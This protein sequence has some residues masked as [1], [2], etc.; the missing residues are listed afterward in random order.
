MRGINGINQP[1]GRFMA[2]LGCPH[3]WGFFYVPRSLNLTSSSVPAGPFAAKDRKKPG[4]KATVRALERFMS[5]SW[6]S[7]SDG[8][9]DKLW[10]PA[11]AKP[12]RHGW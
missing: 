8:V 4:M 9:P 1:N 3:Y 5:M 11:T 10:S 2:G 7:A 6:I 12:W